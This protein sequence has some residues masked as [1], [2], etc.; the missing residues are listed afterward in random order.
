[1]GTVETTGAFV[2]LSARTRAWEKAEKKARLKDAEAADPS[3]ARMTVADPLDAFI[4]RKQGPAAIAQ[5]A[6]QVHAIL[7]ATASG[8]RHLI[9]ATFTASFTP[10]HATMA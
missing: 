4:A 9:I 8:T 2:R 10:R 7:L 6:L 3:P 5:L 1:M